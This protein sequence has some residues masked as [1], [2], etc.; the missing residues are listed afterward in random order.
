MSLSNHP[1]C[2]LS[3]DKRTPTCTYYKC[4]SRRCKKYLEVIPLQRSNEAINNKVP[5]VMVPPRNMKGNV[6][7]S[8]KNGT[9]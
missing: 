4:V 2:Q 8:F 1:L 5:D 9:Y 3:V 7:Q 6:F